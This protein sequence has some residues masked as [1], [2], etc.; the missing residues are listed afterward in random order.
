LIQHKGVLK[1]GVNKLIKSIE[2]GQIEKP[3]ID[4]QALELSLKYGI[5]SKKNSIYLCSQ[6]K[7]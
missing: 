5:L 3:G 1:L 6:T 4:A 7:R 2:S